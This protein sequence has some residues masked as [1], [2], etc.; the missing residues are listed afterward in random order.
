MRPVVYGLY[1]PCEDETKGAREQEHPMSYIIDIRKR[2]VGLQDHFR[3]VG[4]HKGGRAE[5]GGLLS[6]II[7]N[8][9]VPRRSI[10]D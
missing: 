3:L 10:T 6:C 2:F 7:I 4:E 1:K 8:G 5:E 9:Y